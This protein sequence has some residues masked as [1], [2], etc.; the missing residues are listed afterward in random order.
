[1]TS[2]ITSARKT[3]KLHLIASCRPVQGIEGNFG[4]MSACSAKSRW[5][6]TRCL[7]VHALVQETF[8]GS[9]KPLEFD[10]NVKLNIP[11]ISKFSH[12]VQRTYSQGP[13]AVQRNS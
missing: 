1:M 8:F 4:S 10:V 5:A 2:V 3:H 13:R 7:K 11:N 9:L 6:A 12:Q